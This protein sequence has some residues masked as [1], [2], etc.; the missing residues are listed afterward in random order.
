METGLIGSKIG[1]WLV[2]GFSG[3]DKK[4][5]RLYMCR[6][7]CGLEKIIRGAT[8]T[9]GKS[10]MCKPCRVKYE[11]GKKDL[12]GKIIGGAIILSRI[13][14]SDYKPKYLVQ[15]ECGRTKKVPTYRIQAGVSTKC[16]HCRIK[17][18]GMSYTST[19]RIWAG[20]F[21]RCYNKNFKNYSYYGGR[22]IKICDRWNKFENF[23]SDMGE[24]PVGLSIDRINNNGDYEPSNCRWATAKEQ[25]ANTRNSYRD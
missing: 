10:T 6:C 1:Q 3:R 15:C 2:L 11:A 24:R 19:F 16:P 17:T 25:R 20:M 7:D 5:N 4:S 12:T 18:H 21:R 8:L 13:S 14:S 23:L 22:G 9:S